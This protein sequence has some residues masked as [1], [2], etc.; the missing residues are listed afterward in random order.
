MLAAYQKADEI[1][2]KLYRNNPNQYK[3]GRVTVYQ[4][5]AT[6]Y[7]ELGRYVEAVDI[8]EEGLA[9]FNTLPDRE[10]THIASS[11]TTYITTSFSATITLNSIM[12]PTMLLKRF[13][14]S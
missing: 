2:E 7:Y 12:R 1:I 13:I 6:A 11:I 3:I 14:L 8:D 10:K 5:L 4:L 9:I